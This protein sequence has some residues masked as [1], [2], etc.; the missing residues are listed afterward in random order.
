MGQCS[1]R[2]AS[3]NDPVCKCELGVGSWTPTAERFKHVRF[4]PSYVR[5]DISALVHRDNIFQTNSGAFFVQTFRPM[6]WVLIFLLLFTFTLL[7]FLDRRFLQAE[8]EVIPDL[9]GK[10]FFSRARR[11]LLKTQELRRLRYA[12][13]HSLQDMIGRS[14]TTPVMGGNSTRQ[15]VLGIG[16]SLCGLFII[17][18]YEAVVTSVFVQKSVQSGLR[19]IE[20]IR[21]CRIPPRHICMV[22]NAVVESFW[23]N[24][25]ES[26]VQQSCANDEKPL[27]APSFSAAVEMVATGKC[28]FLLE[29][30]AVL[31]ASTGKYCNVL[32]STG[33]KLYSSGDSFIL[34]MNSSLYKPLA[35]ET[36]NLRE[37]GKLMSVEDFLKKRGECPWIEST[38]LGLKTLCPFFIAAFS[39][40]GIMLAIMIFFP[41]FPKEK[42][43]GKEESSNDTSG[44][45]KWKINDMDDSIYSE[46]GSQKE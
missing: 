25:I 37:T 14:S 29:G 31:D 19:T 33:K 40:C 32:L 1:R 15:W 4:L 8:N 20:D 36:L 35:L 22:E 26:Y 11:V 16:I 24:T 6:A 7:R 13:Y 34:P 5:T 9:T 39:F 45:V 44:K 41:Q 21:Q 17:L 38:S 2:T 10:G 23:N 42:Q 12:L 3:P 46:E 18:A 27:F 43:H 28:K 30:P